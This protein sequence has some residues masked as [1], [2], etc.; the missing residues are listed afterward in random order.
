M[1][2]IWIGLDEHTYE[3][4][5]RRAFEE[6]CS[7]SALVRELLAHALE[8]GEAGRGLTLKNFTFIGAGRSR[9]GRLSPVSERHD[10]ALVGTLMEEHRR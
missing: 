7:V 10:Q 5:R 4:L 2:R 1:K 6:G 8:K 3:T 9:Q